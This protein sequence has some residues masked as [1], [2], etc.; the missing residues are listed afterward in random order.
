MSWDIKKCT[1]IL[2]YYLSLHKPNITG[3]NTA[4][5][6]VIGQNQLSSEEYGSNTRGPDVFLNFFS[7][8]IVS[9]HSVFGSCLGLDDISI[10]GKGGNS[11]LI[12]N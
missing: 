10:G 2:S 8:L 11:K 6:I 7:L 4:I 9:P 12:M 5:A 1:I 3:K